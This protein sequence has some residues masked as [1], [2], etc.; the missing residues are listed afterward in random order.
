MMSLQIM[1]FH[2]LL[3][4]NR[5]IAYNITTQKPQRRTP[6][7]IY[8]YVCVRVCVCLCTPVNNLLSR[9]C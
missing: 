3:F 7:Y 9:N 5:P 6:I 8:I 4:E 1:C 2:I